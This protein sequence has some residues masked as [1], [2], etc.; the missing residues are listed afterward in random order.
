MPASALPPHKLNA[1]QTFSN[2]KTK[3]KFHWASANVEVM[4]SSSSNRRRAKL[5]PPRQE[6]RARISCRKVNWE[7]YYEPPPRQE[8][9]GTTS[10][11]Q[12]FK[13]SPMNVRQA[14][15]PKEAL[16]TKTSLHETTQSPHVFSLPTVFSPRK[17]VAC[18]CK[19]SP[20]RTKKRPSPSLR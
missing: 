8:A 10:S 5:A 19:Q 12:T 20:V 14:S 17:N 11:S 7:S 13:F 18:A 6:G 9:R 16:E 3:N 1:K 15:P 4:R 2:N